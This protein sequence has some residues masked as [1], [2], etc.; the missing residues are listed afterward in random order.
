MFSKC[1]KKT[2]PNLKCFQASECV[3]RCEKLLYQS[4]R[5]FQVDYCQVYFWKAK[6][7]CIS[8]QVMKMKM[9]KKSHS[10]IFLQLKYIKLSENLRKAYVLYCDLKNYT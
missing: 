3:R 1:F 7:V 6:S 2:R 8:V 5:S 10:L 9:K 4:Y